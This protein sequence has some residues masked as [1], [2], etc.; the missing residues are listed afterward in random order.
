MLGAA[1]GAARRAGLEQLAHALDGEGRGGAGAEADHH[2]GLHV[3]VDGL[4]ADLRQHG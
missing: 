2:P 3:V 1:G 4:V